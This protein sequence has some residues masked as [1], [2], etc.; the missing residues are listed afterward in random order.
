[1]N[2]TTIKS[3]RYVVDLNADNDDH[4]EILGVWGICS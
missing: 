4:R 1:M 2:L 3:C